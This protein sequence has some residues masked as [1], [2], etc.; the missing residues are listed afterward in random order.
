MKKPTLVAHRGYA[1]RYPDNS[2]ASVR[3]ALDAGARFLEVDVQVSKDGTAYLFHDDDMRR[4]ADHPG[5][6]CDLDD[7]TLATLRASEPDRLGTEFA[8]EPIARLTDLREELLRRPEVFTFVELKPIAIE[9]RGAA[10]VVSIALEAL[11]GL[12][13]RIAVISFSPEALR[14]VRAQSSLPIGVIL[15][16]W[17]QLKEAE[18]QSLAP[19]YVFSNTRHLPWRGEI[20]LPGLPE[21]QLAVYEVI[22]P[23]KAAK[24][25]ERGAAFVETFRFPEMTAALEGRTES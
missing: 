18:V 5:C 1:Y 11:K 4:V 17:S 2:L 9:K 3:A 7:A 21:A 24:L 25:T 8:E 22:D 12:E 6:L 13:D 23:D 19:E 14:E 20:E 16:S 10:R 15:L